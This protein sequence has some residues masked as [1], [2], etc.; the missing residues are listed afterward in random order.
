MVT[1]EAQS[2]GYFVATDQSIA[3]TKTR[4]LQFFASRPDLVLF[5]SDKFHGCIIIDEGTTETESEPSSPTP[6]VILKARLTENKL[7]A[8]TDILG[9]LLGGMEKLADDLAWIYMTNRIIPIE[10]IAF[11]QIDLYG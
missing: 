10:D 3:I 8:T 1:R 7:H 9:L 5:H 4:A 11:L 2:M 6:R